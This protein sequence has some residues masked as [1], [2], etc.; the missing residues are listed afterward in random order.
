MS[1]S[2]LPRIRVPVPGRPAY[3]QIEDELLAMI[4]DGRLPVGAR[5]PAERELARRLGVSRMTLR[6]GLDGLARRGLLVRAGG[7]GT[8]VAERK[9]DQDLRSLRTFPDELRLQGHQEHTAVIR[10]VVVS[11][12]A[13]VAG[14]LGLARGEE[15]R[16]LERLRSSGGVPLVL[17][18]AWIALV[19]LGS[20]RLVGSLW[21]ELARRG[22]AVVRA[23]ER[24]EPVNAS[25]DEAS[26]LGLV[27]G[28]ALMRVERT[29]YDHADLP[30]E[31]AIALFRGDRTTFVVEVSGA[32]RRP[33]P[34]H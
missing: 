15:V 20:D 29:S 16:E 10:D 27:A 5:L 4:G 19:I 17:E 26:A 25:P 11:A 13:R 28:D 2:A 14:A 34:A 21:E 7:R 33:D 1:G 32:P 8:F 9:V 31:H 6:A 24:L 18:T 3:R 30:V 12:S 22:R 23:V